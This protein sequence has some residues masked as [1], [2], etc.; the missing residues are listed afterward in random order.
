MNNADD[1]HK[2]VYWIRACCILH[3]LLTEDY[4]NPE[5]DADSGEESE[6]EEP[7]TQRVIASDENSKREFVKQ[8]VLETIHNE[9]K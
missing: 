5:W 3:N 4:Y 2:T 7:A 1:H 6:E 8:L 9:E